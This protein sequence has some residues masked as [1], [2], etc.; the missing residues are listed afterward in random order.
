MVDDGTAFQVALQE[1]EGYEMALSGSYGEEAKQR[2]TTLGLANIVYGRW[3]KGR[4]VWRV[5]LLTGDM[6]VEP[7]RLET[8]D[9]ARA[10][11]LQLQRAYLSRSQA[12]E[13]A[14]LEQRAK[15]HRQEIRN[16]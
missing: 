4:Q 12:Q 13:L 5:D 14:D 16:V 7:P 3:E 11:N 15:I 10:Y 9:I 8:L 2:A 1:F 6:F